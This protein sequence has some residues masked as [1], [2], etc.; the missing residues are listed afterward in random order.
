M[1]YTAE[2]LDR[3]SGDLTTVS[4]GNWMTVTE[5]GK[6]RGLGARQIRSILLQL[7]LLQEEKIG[8]SGNLRNRLTMRAVEDGLGKRI[9]P[10]KEGQYPFDTLSPKGQQWIDERWDTAV[11][12]NEASTSPAIQ[13]ARIM[14]D[15]FKASRRKG[16]E[17]SLQMEICW[18]VDHFPDMSQVDISKVVDTS[19]RMVSRYVN[20][21]A[22]QLRAAKTFRANPFM[23]EVRK[24]P[25]Y[26]DPSQPNYGAT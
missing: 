24:S 13:Q 11:S 21:R 26:E 15:Q 14:L 1:E 17:F 25:R 16:A 23:D 4:L 2:V 3:S 18:V 5:Y 20:I 9:T 12:A 10:K 19:Q 22:E 8:S 6:T 7:G